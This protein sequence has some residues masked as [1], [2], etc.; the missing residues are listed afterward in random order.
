VVAAKALGLDLVLWRGADGTVN[1]LEDR[2]PHRG[3]PLS[4]GEVQGGT[5]ACVYHG[6]TVD[7]SG[8]IQ[9]VPA[10]RGCVHEG[11]KAVRAFTV[12]EHADG[13]FVYF[14]S[15]ANP[16]PIPLT[17]PFELTGEDYAS[18]LT[19]GV[20]ACNYRYALENLADPMHGIYL[21]AS[22]F[23]LSGGLKE[24]TVE[25]TTT[26]EGF[27]VARVAQQGDNF[28]WVEIVTEA[29]IDYARVNIPYPPGAGPG[30]I[31]RVISFATPIDET[32]TR[33]FFWRCRQ[34]QGLAREA[35]RFLFRAALE[36]RHWEVLEQDRVMLEAMPD[37]ARDHEL[38]YQ[39]DIGVTRLRQILAKRAKL[40]IE[41]EDQAATQ[42]V[43]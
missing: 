38:L 19:T 24:D 37:D 17:L 34:V 6:L 8:V 43:N 41:G 32:S 11:K 10:L 33:I 36:P 27:T 25:M 3:A 42:P 16:D 14:P 23:T 1:C 13:V 5:V 21:H 20:W 39:H 28:D 30:G 40:Q 7:G 26:A 2:C 9:K 15:A 29:G 4:R 18:F 12:R 31:M 35:W 22:S